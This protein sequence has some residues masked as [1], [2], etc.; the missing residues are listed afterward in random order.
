MLGSSCGTLTRHLSTS[1]SAHAQ[2]K[3]YKVLVV[4]GGLKSLSQSGRPMA[5]VL[6]KEAEWLKSKAVTFDPD[7]N[8]VTTEDGTK[9]QYEYAVIAMGIQAN[10]DSV[11]GLKEA[12]ENTSGVCSNYDV[13][14]VE[15]Q[16][17]PSRIFKKAVTLFSHSPSL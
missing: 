13:R 17:M 7:K 6:P 11:K 16:P 10:F 3:S 9:V 4:G 1:I 14:Y 12:L 15:K 5:S 2:E 8:T